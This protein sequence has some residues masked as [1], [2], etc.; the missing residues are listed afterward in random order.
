MR[1]Y[2]LAGAG[3][4]TPVS[5]AHTWLPQDVGPGQSVNVNAV[6]QAPGDPGDYWFRVDLVRDTPGIWF[7]DRNNQ[8]LEVHVRVVAP[9]DDQ[10]A[11]VPV[12]QGD[13]SQLGVNSSNGYLT[14]TAT[15]DSIQELGGTRLFLARAFNGVNAG[16]PPN[17]TAASSPTYGV[18]WTFNFQR[19]IQLGA[20]PGATGRFSGGLYTGAASRGRWSGTPAAGCGRT[21]PATAS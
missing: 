15:D 7:E 9:G 18:G 8:P 13:G 16:L 1:S 17:G 12:T 11:Q 2:R 3:Q 14:I 5:S 10:A 6:F 21:R 20:W 19:S 4:F